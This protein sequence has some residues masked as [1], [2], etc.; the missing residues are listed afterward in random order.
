MLYNTLHYKIDSQ[1]LTIK[2]HSGDNVSI[3]PKTCQLLVLLLKNAGQPVS[4][5]TILAKVWSNSVVAD[6]VVFQSINE[7]R[8]LFNNEEV[9][10]TIPKQGYVWLPAVTAAATA[11][12]KV[13]RY[14]HLWLIGSL[15][16][17]L[18]ITAFIINYLSSDTLVPEQQSQLISGSVVI[19]PVQNTIEGNDHSW[20][21]LG[22]MDQV[23]QRLPNNQEH[24]VLQTDYV[25]EVLERAGAPLIDVK[26]AH[27]N[28]LFTVS[29]AEIIVS[30]KLS[31]TPHDYQLSYVL[32]FK[33]TEQKGVIFARD[34][35]TI[36]D[37]FSAL[38]AKH[39]G[40][41]AVVEP[42]NYH[43]DFNNEMLGVAIDLKLEGQYQAA[44][45]LLESIVISDPKNLT[46]QR[47][48]IEILFE[49]NNLDAVAQ[50]L[51]LAI[52]IAENLNDKAELTRLY[53]L[54]AIFHLVKDNNHQAKQQTINALNV[55]N[56]S[57]DWLFMA[58]S[59]DLLAR[60][61]QTQ[62]DY[63]SAKRFYLEAKAHHQVLKCPVGESSV[64][65]SLALLAKKQNKFDEFNA[66]LNKAKQIAKSRALTEQLKYLNTIK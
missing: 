56:S 15:V 64:W 33:N 54:K 17:C 32:H 3:R 16:C 43:A 36:T 63:D 29:G 12:H 48:L 65:A 37:Q 51:A 66:A 40:T 31:G 60:I 44:K 34:I 62:G 28:Q 46:A 45:P 58:Y 50:R 9:I 22:M 27:I 39:I 24:G 10:K 59:K 4:K 26:S 53:Y 5:Q 35:Q 30:S 13:A 11:T 2:T 1:A 14:S 61:A 18:A 19:L 42:H 57:N 8:Q 52:P 6:Q 20:V 49:A 38:V 55:A 41:N 21:R 23:I 7:L 25:L 47:I